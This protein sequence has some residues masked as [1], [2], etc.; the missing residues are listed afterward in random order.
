MDGANVTTGF[1]PLNPQKRATEATL[2]PLQITT[3]T[4]PSTLEIEYANGNR[5]RLPCG[6]G[7]SL[8]S[9]AGLLQVTT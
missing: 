9:I 3:P 8:E 4:L 7:F 5:L 2:R 6:E 1:I